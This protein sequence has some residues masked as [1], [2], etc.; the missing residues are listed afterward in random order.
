MG[1]I[2][3]IGAL[4]YFDVFDS[5]RFVS[6]RCDLGTQIQ[7][8][9]AYANDQ[10][11]VELELKNDYLVDID[12]ESVFVDG[13][14][15]YQYTSSQDG[16]FLKFGNSSVFTATH[17]GELYKGDKKE[18]DVLVVFRRHT[19]S[20]MPGGCGSDSGSTCYNLSGTIVVKVQDA[21]KIPPPVRPEN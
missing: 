8:I 15:L 9:G 4:A 10:E 20:N 11:Y 5:K 21:A 1:V 14:Q 3:V 17:A 16:V 13:N 12:I 19:P 6:E 2:I 18:M 7:C